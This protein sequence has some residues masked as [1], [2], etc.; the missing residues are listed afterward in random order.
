MDANFTEENIRFYALRRRD[1]QD[2]PLL[3]ELPYRREHKPFQG[4]L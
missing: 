1:R 2:Q 4:T 3:H